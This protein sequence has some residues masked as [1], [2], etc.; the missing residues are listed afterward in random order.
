MLPMF[1]ITVDIPESWRVIV[2]LAYPPKYQTR[3]LLEK[4]NK[5][6]INHKNPVIE[7][8]PQIK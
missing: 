4:Q 2:I 3:T 7:E 6:Y 1:D 5:N 8:T